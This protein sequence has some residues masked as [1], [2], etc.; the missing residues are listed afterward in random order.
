MGVSVVI[1]AFNAARLIGAAIASAQAQSQPPDE[2]IVIDDCSTDDTG[3][4]VREMMASDDR[5]A[6][7]RTPRNSGP[8]AA[9]N[10]GLTRAGGDW[11][12]LLDADDAFDRDRLEQLTGLAGAAGVDMV[13]DNIL[14]CAGDVSEPVPMYRP[15]ELP[16]KPFILST[17]RFVDGCVGDRRRPRQS[18]G[19][20][21]PLMARS[22]LRHHRL[23]YVEGARFGEDF[24]LYLAC[25]AAGAR[26]LVTPQP[27]YRYTIRSGSLTER[28]SPADLWRVRTAIQA[29]L[30]DPTLVPGSP[31]ARSGRR[32]RTRIDHNYFYRAFT[33]AVKSGAGYEALRVLF[34]SFASPGHVVQ[35]S[36]EQMPTILRKAMAGGYV[37]PRQKSRTAART[38]AGD[39]AAS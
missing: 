27:M 8:G 38:P 10:L 39:A 3:G 2:I 32:C 1:P 18:L 12:A 34:S 35:A 5:I 11:I 33:D 14:C 21:Q 37:S 13:S 6:L 26:W 30:D 4:V 20:M 23:R 15:D 19:F 28:Q 7:L 16:T 22:F 17:A 31:L 29:M 36:F 9:R 25:L 24:L